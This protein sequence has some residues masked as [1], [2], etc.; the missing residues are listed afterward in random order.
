MASERLHKAYTVAEKLEN[1]RNLVTE[2]CSLFES[3]GDGYVPQSLSRIKV[4][5]WNAAD[6]YRRDYLEVLAT[7]IN[8]EDL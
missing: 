3:E 5:L 7:E 4:M 2:V 1:A 6:S 8:M